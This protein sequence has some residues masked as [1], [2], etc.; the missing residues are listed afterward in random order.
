MLEYIISMDA[1]YKQQ[2]ARDN[3]YVST[4]ELQELTDISTRRV[5]YWI[6]SGVFGTPIHPGQGRRLM[7]HRSVIP[8][9]TILNELAMET[10]EYRISMET[11]RRVVENFDIGF[12]QYSEHVRI[13]WDTED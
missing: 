13:Q 12:I 3:G 1:G 7:W 8:V 11:L 6:R 5:Y 2:A 9:I 4:I 10:G